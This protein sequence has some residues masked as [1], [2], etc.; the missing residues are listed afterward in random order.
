MALPQIERQPLG[1]KIRAAR[2]EQ[3]TGKPA[4]AKRALFRFLAQ[5]IDAEQAG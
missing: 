3:A 4:G 5:H 1:Q 2:R